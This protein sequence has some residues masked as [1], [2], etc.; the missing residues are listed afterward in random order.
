MSARLDTAELSGLLSPQLADLAAL[1]EAG[2]AEWLLSLPADVRRNRL[3]YLWEFWARPGQRWQPGEEIITLYQA[4]R[5][6]G[7]TRIGAEAVI[8]VASHP[9][10]C[11]FGRAPLTESAPTIALVARTAHDACETM[12]RGQSGILACSPPWFRPR[13]LP[14]QKLLVWP[15]GMRAYYYTAERPE[16]LRGPNIAFAW[17]DEI[18]FFKALRGEQVGALENIEQALR[19]GLGRAV[20]TTTPIP[21]SAMFSL[22]ERAKPR[23]RVTFD[24]RPDHRSPEHAE[25]VELAPDHR[26]DDRSGAEGPTVPEVRIVRGSSLDNAANQ[27]PKWVA[28]QRAKRGTR[29]GRQEVDGELLSGNPRTLFPYE[30]LNSRRVT[31][32]EI[33][34][35]APGESRPDYLRRVLKLEKIC[36]A[37]D[38]NGSDDLDNAEFGIQVCGLGVDGREYSLADM[39]GHHGPMVWPGLIYDTALLWGAEA[40]V[41]E[42]NYGGS[43]IRAAVETHVRKLIDAGQDYL[44]IQFVEVTTGK[45]G[46]ASR[47]KVFAQAYEGRLVWSV[48]DPSIWA[49]LEAQLHSFD[50]NLHPDKQVARMEVKQ[51]DGSVKMETLLLDRMDARVWGHLYL[52]GHQI[53]R[54]RTT[55]WLGDKA[56]AA[57]DMLASLR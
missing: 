26:P 11:G 20:Y 16:T 9:E 28:R 42:T 29:V 27:D 49:S 18:A 38:P 30:L 33:D 31:P 40:I 53:A 57:V 15:N 2:R 7:K 44:P 36:V 50:S 14:S 3:P 1:D 35:Q 32:E 22:H 6:F 37:A 52:S 21:T 48:G 24:Q 34:K 39:S 51:P 10:E 4:G 45:A 17:A 5:G 55:F 19:K 47:L 8:W 56:Q 25:A 43:M 46:K 12:I 23:A 13:F 54:N 41:A